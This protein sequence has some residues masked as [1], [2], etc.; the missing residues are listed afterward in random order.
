MRAAL[1]GRDAVAVVV[2]PIVPPEYD[3]TPLVEGS[4]DVVRVIAPATELSLPLQVGA[5]GLQGQDVRRAR[6]WVVDG[7]AVSEFQVAA[8]FGRP[9]DW[10]AYAADLVAWLEQPDELGR[11]LEEIAAPYRHHQRASAARPAPPRVIVDPAGSGRDTLVEVRVA[12]GIG[13]L[14]RIT[15]A[16]VGLDLRVHRAF[17]S[18]LGH[19][20]VDTFYVTGTDGAP[21]ARSG[22]CWPASNRPSWP[23]SEPP[24]RAKLSGLRQR[25]EPLS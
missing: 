18:T 24:T 5:L 7:V 19:E 20:V 1:A 4:D 22:P 8:R 3:G 13:V 17:V 12:D 23:R 16:L 6:S 15:Q 14:Y 10:T 21:G 2:A 25:P 9:A 11:R